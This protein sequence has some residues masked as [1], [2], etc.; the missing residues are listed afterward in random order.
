M[1][2]LAYWLNLGSNKE[3]IDGSSFEECSGSENT[4]HLA[5]KCRKC[6]REFQPKIEAYNYCESCY[7][8]WKKTF[9]PKKIRKAFAYQRKFEPRHV[10]NLAQ[11]ILQDQPNIEIK[12][13]VQLFIDEFPP[14]Q[15]K[16]RFF[17]WKRLKHETVLEAI[18][19]S[20][21]DVGND[22]VRK[23]EI[24]GTRI[25]C[26]DIIRSLYFNERDIWIKDELKSRFLWNS[27]ISPKEL[28]QI[29]INI[30]KC[31]PKNFTDEKIMSDDYGKITQ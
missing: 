13:F 30:D 16:P 21:K 28:R 31:D 1:G 14:T 23:G 9:V 25:K 7:A 29:A 10:K 6:K 20:S 19:K 22:Y 12:N 17:P 3:N 26:I 18:E 27:R 2:K 5:K 8:N 15:R 24:P 4:E 11:T